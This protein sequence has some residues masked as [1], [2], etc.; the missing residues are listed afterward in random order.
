LSGAAAGW[1]TVTRGQQRTGIP[2][3]GIMWARPNDPYLASLR[4]GLRDLGYIDGKTIKIEDRFT[5]NYDQLGAIA[6][7]L[8]ESKVDVIVAITTATAVAA[9]RATKTIPVVFVYV[10]DPVGSRIVESLAHPGG[11]ATGLASMSLELAAKEIDIF[12]EIT[13][14]FSRLAILENSTYAS[15]TRNADDIEMAAKRLKI[16]VDRF[17]ATTPDDLA[18]MLDEIGKRRPDGLVITID[19]MF[20]RQGRRIA[21]LAIAE[22]LPTMSFTREATAAGTLMSYGADPSDLC[23]RAGAYVDKILR[24]TQPRDLPVE[25]PTKLEL[26]INQRTAKALGLTIPDKL[27]ALADDVIE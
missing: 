9:T 11:N 25:E 3:I 7:E 21:E 8:V 5:E 1:P 26:V 4:D 16:S 6:S 2:R 10:S 19:V 17:D 23:R 14:N 12:K 20:L 27:L 15:S 18:K 22:H 13:P 24:G